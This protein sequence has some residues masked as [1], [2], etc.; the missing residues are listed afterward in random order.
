MGGYNSY[1]YT[2][3][4]VYLFYIFLH[5]VDKLYFYEVDVDQA[6]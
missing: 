5:N 3:F 2:A 6:L 1:F 4:V